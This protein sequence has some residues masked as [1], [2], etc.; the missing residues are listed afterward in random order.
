MSPPFP[1]NRYSSYPA[2]FPQ[3]FSSCV[4]LSL[5][6]HPAA[7]LDSFKCVAVTLLCELHFCRDL[8][9]PRGCCERE[10]RDSQTALLFPNLR[11]YR[12]SFHMP[13]LLVCVVCTRIPTALTARIDHPRRFTNP[14]TISL[15]TTSICH[16]RCIWKSTSATSSQPATRLSERPPETRSFM[17]STCFGLEGCSCVW[18][19]TVFCTELGYPRA[20][21]N[22]TR[23]RHCYSQLVPRAPNVTHIIYPFAFFFLILHLSCLSFFAASYF[24]QHL[25]L[26]FASSL[27]R[28]NAPS[29]LPFLLFFIYIGLP[30]MHLPVQQFFDAQPSRNEL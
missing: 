18:V 4:I 17:R 20:S 3:V 16:R 29:K 28:A 9:V 13:L 25:P 6:T 14:H 5:L 8:I 26:R 30:A 12:N 7:N 21:R 10:I 15:C 11:Y 27:L 22:V 24:S 1:I 2:L 19:F 23:V